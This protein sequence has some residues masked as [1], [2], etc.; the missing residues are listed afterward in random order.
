MTYSRRD[1]DGG[2]VLQIR[3][4]LDAVSAFDLRPQV[5]ALA[6]ERPGRVVV[7]LSELNLIDSTGVGLLVSLYKR[8]REGGGRLQVVGAK[9]QPL[10][11]LRLLRLDR[12]LSP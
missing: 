1:Q 12:V 2:T 3:G 8:L 9:A 6:A 10:A 7:D 4:A 11:I 5:D